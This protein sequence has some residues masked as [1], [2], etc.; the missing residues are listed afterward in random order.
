MDYQAYHLGSLAVPELQYSL[1]NGAL[2]A[3]QNQIKIPYELYAI[4]VFSSDILMLG[5]Y[6]FLIE[7]LF[8]G[9]KVAAFLVFFGS[10]G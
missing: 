1:P 5:F 3:R 6:K 10:F 2:P 9:F 8:F 7:S 4:L